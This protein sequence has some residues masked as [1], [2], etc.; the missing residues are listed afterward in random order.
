MFRPPL[1]HCRAKTISPTWFEFYNTGVAARDQN[2]K[3]LTQRADEIRRRSESITM[4]MLAQQAAF[5][6]LG[7]FLVTQLNKDSGA[8]KTPTLRDIELTGPYM[9]NGSIKTLLDVVRFY[10]EG[11]VHNPMLM[12]HRMRPLGLNERQISDIVEFLRALT[13]DD[14]LKLAQFS[15]HR[16]AKGWCT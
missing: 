1:K 8:F 4:G 11:G 13:S 5:S 12:S 2:F 14:V 15:S 7:R 16:H 10:N 3:K 6:E 9:H